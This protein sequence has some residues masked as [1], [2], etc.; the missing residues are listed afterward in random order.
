MIEGMNLSGHPWIINEISK[1]SETW[2][3]EKDQKIS[4]SLSLRFFQLLILNYPFLDLDC[5]IERLSQTAS[6]QPR[7][8]P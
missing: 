4:N 5:L 7:Y 1:G 3:Q 8:V 6:N 2:Q